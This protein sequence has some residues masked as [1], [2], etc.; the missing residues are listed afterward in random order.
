MFSR[1]SM[2]NDLRENI[3][4]V[5]FRRGDGTLRVMKAT[6][7]KDIL[8]PQNLPIMTEEYVPRYENPNLIQVWDV[9]QDAWR[10]F[11]VDSVESFEVV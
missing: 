10:S 2:V 1:E 11:R 9:E 3:C 6:L 7:R 5:K 8:P 4:Q